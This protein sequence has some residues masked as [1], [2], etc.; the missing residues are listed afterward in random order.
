MKVP[1]ALFSGGHDT[2]ADPKDVAVL[3]TQVSL[4]AAGLAAVWL[5]TDVP[6]WPFTIKVSR[7]SDLQLLLQVFPE[8]P[9]CFPCSL[10]N[11]WFSSCSSH[12]G[13][14]ETMI[15]FCPS[16]GVQPGLPSAH[17]TLGTPGFYL[18]LGCSSADVPVHP[19]A[20]AETW[21]DVEDSSGPA[22]FRTWPLNQE[23]IF[24]SPGDCLSSTRL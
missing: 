6:R 15:L 9:R 7:T 5:Q 20:A 23:R 2:L 14:V 21:L 17:W 22:A 3:L 13:L 24:L 12:G 16:A 10:L 4:S 11:S 1:T 19:E 8:F 18:G